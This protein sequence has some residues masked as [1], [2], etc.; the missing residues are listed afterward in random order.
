MYRSNWY[1]PA[2][3]FNGSFFVDISDVIHL[4]CQSLQCYQTEIANR[5]PEWIESFIDRE[6]NVGFAIGKAY[7]EAFEPLKLELVGW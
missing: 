1:Q 5:T 4:K 2:A 3:P 7:A 6:R